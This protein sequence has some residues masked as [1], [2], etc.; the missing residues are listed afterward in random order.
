[1]IAA[2]TVANGARRAAVVT[3]Q[4]RSAQTVPRFG[5]EEQMK[6]EA[7][8]Q[9]KARIAAQKEISKQVHHDEAAEIA[10]MWKWV[11]ISFAVAFPVC[12]LSSIKDLFAD[13]PHEKEGPKPDYMAIRSK[14]FPWECE[15]CA[16]FDPKCWKKCRAEQA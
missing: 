13:H 5:T 4:R 8:E 3:T 7:L 6:A 12:V 1:M 2:R 11:K 16:L 14:A 9:L 15:D 10:E